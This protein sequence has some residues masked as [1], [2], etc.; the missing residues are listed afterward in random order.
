MQLHP[1]PFTNSVNIK[2]SEG[3]ESYKVYNALGVLAEERTV[4]GQNK[5]DL[6]IDLGELKPG[7]YFLELHT[8]GGIFTRK[9][10]KSFN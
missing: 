7:I 6:Q 2:V 3:I 10:V 1:N 4:D 8:T 5:R 9:I